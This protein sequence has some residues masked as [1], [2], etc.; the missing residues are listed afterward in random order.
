[1]PLFDFVCQQCHANFE[2]LVRG[3]DSLRCPDCQGTQL[4]KLLGVPAA[5]T[6]RGSSTPCELPMAPGPCGQGGCGLPQ[7]GSG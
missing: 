1:M 3:N 2:L 4:E 7:C 5:H 6:G